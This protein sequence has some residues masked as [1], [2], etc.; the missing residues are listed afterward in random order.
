MSPITTVPIISGRGGYTRISD[1][2]SSWSALLR[3]SLLWPARM[4]I[5]RRDLARL[6]ALDDRGL[7]DIG[8]TRQDLRN[9][10]ALPRDEN[11]TEFLAG[12]AAGRARGR[13]SRARRRAGMG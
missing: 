4:L 12:V 9:A 10:T 13:W 8:L 6:A 2:G 1:R 3:R 5:A 7:R 11:P